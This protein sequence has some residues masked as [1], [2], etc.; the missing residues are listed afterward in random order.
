QGRIFEQV[1]LHGKLRPL[2]DEKELRCLSPKA[3]ISEIIDLVRNSILAA[4]TEAELNMIRNIFGEKDQKP[5]TIKYCNMKTAA[6]KY[7]NTDPDRRQKFNDLPPFLLGANDYQQQRMQRS[8]ASV[9][10]MFPVKIPSAYH[11]G[12]TSKRFRDM[13]NGLRVQNGDYSSLTT[14][15]KAKGTK[16]LNHNKFDVE[17]LPVMFKKILA[18]NPKHI[19]QSTQIVTF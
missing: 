6:M 2:A 5:Q 17:V 18:D 13:L 3:F 9:A 4:Y 16:A 15:Q 14:T 12:Q 10:R 1:I 8:L 19:K 7:I 11:P